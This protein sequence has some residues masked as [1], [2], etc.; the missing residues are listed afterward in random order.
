MLKKRG[1]L[2]GLLFSPFDAGAG[3]EGRDWTCGEAALR[4]A[5]ATWLAGMMVVRAL[6]LGA[7][8]SAPTKS[9]NTGKPPCSARI[10]QHEAT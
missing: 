8:E 3:L 10:C 9:W 6:A 7:T 5:D 4:G 1:W 2:S